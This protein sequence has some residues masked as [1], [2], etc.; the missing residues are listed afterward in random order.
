MHQPLCMC[1]VQGFGDGCHQS[2]CLVETETCFLHPGGKVTPLD[3]LGNDEAQSILGAPHVINRHD[4]GMVK[5]GNDAGFGEVCLDK[6]R[7]RDSLPARDFDRNP[8]PELLVNGQ[9]DIAE[10]A[11]PKSTANRV[12]PDLERIEKR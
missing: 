7:L 4:V 1:V 12:P 6:L 9:E 11:L 3:A 5:I 2:H 8:P 10:P